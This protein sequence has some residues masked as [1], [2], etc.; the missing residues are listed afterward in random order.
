MAARI[1]CMGTRAPAKSQL[2]KFESYKL[3]VFYEIHDSMETAI[4]TEKKIKAGSRKEKLKL[5]KE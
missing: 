4:L 5:M 1:L 2:L 3:L